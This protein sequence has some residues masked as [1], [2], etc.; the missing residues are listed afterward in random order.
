M[1]FKEN[2][3]RFFTMDRHQDAG[4][5]LVELIVVI[6]ILGILAGIAI[7]T[8]SGYIE[9]ANI[10]ADQQMMSS[11]NTC[12]AAAAAGEGFSLAQLEGSTLLVSADG[13]VTGLNAQLAARS[14]DVAAVN[15]DFMTFFGTGHKFKT[16][17]ENQT[18]GANGFAI[19][20]IEGGNGGNGGAPVTVTVT[21]NED[22][23]VTLTSSNG[24][25]VTLEKDDMA[26]V[27]GSTF[28]TAEGLGSKGLL[29][30]V[31]YVTNFA[32]ALLNSGDSEAFATIMGGDSY[33]QTLAAAMGI[34][35]AS[36]LTGED[37]DDAIDA[38]MVEL[39]Y[40]NADDTQTVLANGAVLYAAQNAAT[41][42]IKDITK[43]LTENG[44]K[45]NI[46]N[47][48]N[49]NPGQTMAQ[50]ALAYGMYTAYAYQSG[51][52]T[53]I[54]QIE[55]SDPTAILNNL[56]DDAFEAYVKSAK[57]QNDLQAY[58]AALGMINEGASN[59]GNATTVL[60][61]GFNTPE[62][63]A[64]LNSVMGTK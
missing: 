14:G 7:P 9:R 54:A 39:G 28:G 50:S 27:A 22:G 59:T 53:L 10:A 3:K 49:T 33:K 63:E 12:F 43:L 45:T 1:K 8:Y 24:M 31:E 48:L 42:D 47:N 2:F 16:I 58:M 40:D 38:K 5:T 44:T 57:G 52:A 29:N 13:T 34:T 19:P 11:V 62:L 41:M 35:N 21:E 64:M 56:D 36:T 17:K 23:T 30:R 32:E 4:F 61:S 55:N 25:T 18:A 60:G 51:N 26:L 20:G 6:A 37:L 15:S 46:A